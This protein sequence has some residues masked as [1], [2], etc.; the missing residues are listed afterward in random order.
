MTGGPAAYELSFAR[1]VSF[2]NLVNG[3]VDM[4]PWSTE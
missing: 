4:T 3:S 1:L 2:A